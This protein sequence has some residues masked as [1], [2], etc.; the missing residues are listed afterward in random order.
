MLFDLL[1]FFLCLSEVVGRLAVIWEDMLTLFGPIVSFISWFRRFDGDRVII[2]I[3]NKTMANHSFFGSHMGW[4]GI[5][6]SPM[7]ACLRDYETVDHILWGWERFDAER[8]TGT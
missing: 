5:V 8:L 6:E 4:I 2:S 7:C 3:I 1:I